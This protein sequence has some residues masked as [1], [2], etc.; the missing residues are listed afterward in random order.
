MSGEFDDPGPNDEEDLIGVWEINL[1]NKEVNFSSSV[2][3]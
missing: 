3:H 1:F 2:E